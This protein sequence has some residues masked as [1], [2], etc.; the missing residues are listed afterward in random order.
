SAHGGDVAEVA[1]EE[2]AADAGGRGAIVEMFAVDD[3]ID[4]DQLGTSRTG[5][6]GAIIAHAG[7]GGGTGVAQPRADGR[8]QP[9]LTQ[10]GDR[11][12]ALAGEGGMGGRPGHERMRGT[13]AGGVSISRG[14]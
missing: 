2:L 5:E 9:V 3:G 12:V 10:R 7:R 14:E 1:V 8:D 11:M 6:H 4:R 13:E